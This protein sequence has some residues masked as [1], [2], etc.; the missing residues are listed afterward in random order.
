MLGANHPSD[1]FYQKPDGGFNAMRVMRQDL[2][3]VCWQA[4]MGKGP[5]RDAYMEGK[6]RYD[7][8]WVNRSLDKNLEVCLV[9]WETTS[10]QPRPN[11][12]CR[13]E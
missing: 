4:A 8:W 11:D 13:F 2:V 5:A 3:A 1:I 7:D 10:L 6:R 9:Y 12:A